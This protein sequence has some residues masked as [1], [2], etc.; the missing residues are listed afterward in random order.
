MLDWKH[1]NIDCSANG[2][3]PIYII[4]K[5]LIF[6]IRERQGVRGKGGGG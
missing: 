5:N 4:I 3:Q 2:C 1:E 6:P